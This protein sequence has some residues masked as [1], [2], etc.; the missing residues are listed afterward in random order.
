M[1]HT[2][3]IHTQ[4]SQDVA[5]EY[6]RKGTLIR[7]TIKDGNG[8]QI[9]C[10][11]NADFAKDGVVLWTYPVKKTGYQAVLLYARINFMKLINAENRVT[12][13]REIDNSRCFAA[14]ER[15]IDE[16]FPELPKN[17][18]AWMVSRLDYC[19]NIKTDYCNEY[20]KLG[21]R[22]RLYRNAH[23]KNTQGGSVYRGNKSYT[24]NLYNKA[25]EIL[26]DIGTRTDIPPKE[27]GLYILDG[28]N[29][30]RVE[31]QCHRTKLDQLAKKYRV[32]KK[33]PEL[34]R[35]EIAQDVL[36]D[37]LLTSV[38][39]EPYVRCRTALE[40]AGKLCKTKRKR[41]RLE[42]VIKGITK[43]SNITTLMQQYEKQGVMSGQTFDGYCKMLKSQN[44]N[45]VI[46]P[47]SWDLGGMDSLESIY[48]LFLNQLEQMCDLSQERE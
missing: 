23:I 43:C 35:N 6:F 29:V 37:A 8:K 39:S 26:D 38:G 40:M 17:I 48:D 28:W 46:I 16:H 22:A 15:L 5:D 24:L 13:A 21:N 11:K 41:E 44:V 10:W 18:D 45:P 14:F 33:L 36:G 34:C 20:V 3:E 47:D 31:V 32:A 19:I 2:A 25:S 30:L 9:T 27:K 1:W 7:D 42:T 4:I 12:V